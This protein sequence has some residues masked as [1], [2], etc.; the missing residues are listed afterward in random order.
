LIVK[1]AIGAVLVILA[2]SFP[3]VL[4]LPLLTT[5]ISLISYHEIF[6]AQVAYDLFFKDK[7][8]FVIVFVFGFVIPTLKMILSVVCWYSS[9]TWLGRYLSPKIDILSKLSML[10]IMLLAVFIIVFK[11]V[12]IAV[13]QVRYG[14]YVYTGLVVASLIVNVLVTHRA[15]AV[16]RRES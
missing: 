11:G 14:L 16:G 10:D 3:F 8:L 12:G 7:F 9:E 4:F 5:R 1:H 6:L 2:V 13:V 15:R